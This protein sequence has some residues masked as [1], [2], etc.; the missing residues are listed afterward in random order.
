MLHIQVTESE[1]IDS[2][3]DSPSLNFEIR[4]LKTILQLLEEEMVVL[5]T[6]LSDSEEEIR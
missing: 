3:N 2:E 4:Q 6:K 5:Q 1:K